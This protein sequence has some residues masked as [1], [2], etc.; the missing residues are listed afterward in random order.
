MPFL[1]STINDIRKRRVSMPKNGVSIP[2]IGNKRYKSS[3]YKWLYHTSKW[4]KIRHLFLMEHP[5]CECEY[6][7]KNKTYWTANVVHHK[8]PHKGNE[9]LFWDEA[10]FMAMNKHCHDK[11]EAQLKVGGQH[12]KPNVYI[13]WGAPGSGKSTYVNS[14]K[15]YGDLVV[16]LDLIN[17]ALT[18]EYKTNIPDNLVSTMIDIRNYIYTLISNNKILT[19][20]IYVIAGLPILQQR[21]EL[22]NM[23]KATDLIF[24]NKSKEEC[25]SNVMQDS[26]RIDKDKQIIIINKWFDLY[27]GI[28]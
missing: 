17:Q 27:D 14:K 20:N 3:S 9:I 26:S 22:F 4:A 7:I 1:P 19:N 6:C 12:M 28:K 18:L 11:Y 25:I 21:K 8:I 16:D 24:I 13:I 23:L 5:L 2:K 15:K 10:N